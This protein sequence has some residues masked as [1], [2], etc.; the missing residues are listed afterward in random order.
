M[1]WTKKYRKSPKSDEFNSYTLWELF[2]EFFEDYYEREPQEA[3]ESGA[4]HITGDP[5]IDKWERELAQGLVPDLSEGLA[6]DEYSNF[7]G[8]SRE[9]Y[10]KKQ[11]HMALPDEINET[12]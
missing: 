6:P 10:R 11:L 12:Y 2:V 7:I 1:W 5:V 3:H 9:V 8:W 4:P